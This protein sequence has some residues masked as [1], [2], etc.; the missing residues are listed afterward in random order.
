MLRRETQILQ[1]NREKTVGE[2]NPSFEAQRLKTSASRSKQAIDSKRSRGH[3]T[4]LI[5]L[6]HPSFEFLPRMDRPTP[7]W[8]SR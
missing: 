5:R 2:V 1:C 7:K 6:V 3:V 8:T 4:T